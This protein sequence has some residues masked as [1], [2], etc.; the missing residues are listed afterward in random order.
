MS[1]Q[2][3]NEKTF[4][5]VPHLEPITIP[6]RPDVAPKVMTIEGTIGATDLKLLMVTDNIADAM[7]HI[8]QHGIEPFG[9]R[10]RVVKPS[11]L[12]GE[13]NPVRSLPIL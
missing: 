2:M 10:R 13:R 4:Q 7:A 1:R 3:L 9:L 6:G 12:L 5:N 8:H 11:P